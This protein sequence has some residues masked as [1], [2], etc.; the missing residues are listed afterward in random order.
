MDISFLHKQMKGIG[1]MDS[2]EKIILWC[3]QQSFEILLEFQRVCEELGLRYYLSGGTLLGAIR[4]KGF[5]PWDDDIDLVM[6][7][8][9]YNKLTKIGPKYFSEKFFYQ[10]YHTEPNYPHYFSRLRKRGPA[11]DTKVLATIKMEHGWFIDIFPLDRCPD[12]EKATILLFKGM[13]F[14][15]RILIARVST[16]TVYSTCNYTKWYVRLL[17]HIFKSFP[18]R[19]LFFLRECFRK[20]MECFSTGKRVCITGGMA[21]CPTDVYRAE[22][23]KETVPVQFEGHTFPAPAEWDIYL[24]NLYGDYMV[25]PPEEE[26]KGHGMVIVEQNVL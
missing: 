5:I 4:H 7:R 6:P 10:S 9:D 14:F 3:Q 17:W 20:I 22:W 16:K 21:G 1:T 25:L 11:V 23:F 8:K 18:N 24:R 2:Q 12:W 13:L 26:R 15:R 19:W